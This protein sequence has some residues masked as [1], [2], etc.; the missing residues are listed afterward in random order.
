MP[1][2]DRI[3]S[4]VDHVQEPPD[5]WTSRLSGDRVPRLQGGRWLVDG[6]PLP[7]RGIA[8]AGAL[9]ADRS[10]ALDRWEDVPRA[11]YQPAARLRAMDA[12]G[13]ECSVLYPTV[14]GIGGET[15]GRLTDA[16]L[17]L[18][19]VRAYNDWLIDQ[20]AA[21]SPRFVPQCIVPLFPAEAAAAEVE[22]AV[23]RGHRGVIY[24]AVPMELRDVP[25]VNE[26]AYDPLWD[27]CQR[28]NVPLC[29]RAGSASSIQSP[30]PE[31]MPPAIAEAYRSI[32]GSTSL[33]CVLV[34][35]LVSGILER[36]PRLNVV[37]AGSGLGWGAY[38][39][40]YTD[41]QFEAN[42]LLG[43]GHEHL[44]S[45]LFRRQCHLTGWYGRAGVEARR[46]VGP[47]NILW[48]TNFPLAT[49]SWPTTRE[50]VDRAFDGV[51]DGERERMLRG[52]AAR[53]YRL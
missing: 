18:D 26:R 31:G 28:L 33:I 36:F 20:W 15:F 21:A 32:T 8:G 1:A 53:L 6:R 46:F 9:L 23:G 44:P 40:E 42:G 41:Q 24:P 10:A 47:G 39:F 14:A 51:P 13:V 45:E 2:P 48:S 43:P 17:E 19:C 37:F 3:V 29:I 11:A 38:Q 16:A 22:R 12:D 49:S 34:N 5:L 27:V 4:T 52:N 25:H 50:A 7:M 35:L 30:L